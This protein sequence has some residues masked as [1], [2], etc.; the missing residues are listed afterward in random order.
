MTIRAYQSKLRLSGLLRD[1][2]HTH[3][4]THTQEEALYTELMHLR[5]RASANGFSLIE[6][7]IVMGVS[8]VLMTSILTLT[9]FG[10]QSSRNITQ[11]NDFSNL[12]SLT[13]MVVKSPSL[14]DGNVALLGAFDLAAVSSNVSSNTTGIAFTSLRLFDNSLVQ[15]GLLVDLT[16]SFNKLKRPGSNSILSS[17]CLLGQETFRW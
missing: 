17:F 5:A 16:K 4:H 2:L 15:T 3:T 10:L 9:R 12:V 14:C 1:V 6:L 8:A 11:L 13:Q 7:L